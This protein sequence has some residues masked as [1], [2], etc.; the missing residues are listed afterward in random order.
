MS[1]GIRGVLKLGRS[2]PVKKKRILDQKKDQQEKRKAAAARASTSGERKGKK[3]AKV[4]EVKRKKEKAPV[5]KVSCPAFLNADGKREFGR[6]I[7]ELGKLKHGK[8]SAVTRLDRGALAAYCQAYADLVDAARHLKEEGATTII[9]D[10]P[11]G[12][13]KEGA[14]KYIQQSPWVSI[15]NKAL[16]ALKGLAAELGLTPASRVRNNLKL[17]DAGA[18][19]KEKSKEMARILRLPS[20]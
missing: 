1:F 16:I 18:K 8:I 7:K 19:E 14:I 9:R 11:K 4:V 17:E 10:K 15:K 2:G 12:K 20:G 13:K 6:V 5:E 3:K